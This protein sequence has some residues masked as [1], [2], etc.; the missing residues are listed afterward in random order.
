MMLEF[1]SSILSCGLCFGI[2]VDC[3]LWLCVAVRVVRLC[4]RRNINTS[5]WNLE[6]Q[7]AL[8]LMV[9]CMVDGTW[10]MVDTLE[11]WMLFLLPTHVPIQMR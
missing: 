8:W 3:G 10:L 9:W 4:V 6:H 2:C 11:I 1:G 5:T 7:P